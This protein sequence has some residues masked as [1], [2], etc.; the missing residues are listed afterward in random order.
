MEWVTEGVGLCS[1]MVAGSLSPQVPW[2]PL[3][4]FRET[5][6]PFAAAHFTACLRAVAL[7]AQSFCEAILGTHAPDMGRLVSKSLTCCA[8][9][10]ILCPA[11]GSTPGGMARK[12]RQD[13]EVATVFRPCLSGCCFRRFFLSHARASGRFHSG[14]QPVFIFHSRRK[15]CFHAAAQRVLAKPGACEIYSKKI[16]QPQDKSAKIPRFIPKYPATLG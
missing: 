10:G 8:V 5:G 15:A 4:F 13:R 7:R 3:S 1:G 14:A 11:A 9:G 12:P 6:V 2:V 16:L